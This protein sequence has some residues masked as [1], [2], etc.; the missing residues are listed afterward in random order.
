LKHQVTDVGASEL[1]VNRYQVNRYRFNH[2][3]FQ[4]E[5]RNQHPQRHEGL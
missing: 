1:Q 5:R 3:W 2:H 4:R